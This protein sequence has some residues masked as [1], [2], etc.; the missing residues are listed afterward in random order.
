MNT[1]SIN[2]G[3]NRWYKDPSGG[4]YSI[5]QV[6]EIMFAEWAREGEC[7]AILRRCDTTGKPVDGSKPIQA[8]LYA[9]FSDNGIDFT[10]S[11]A[12]AIAPKTI[13]E[14]DRE[15]DREIYEHFQRKIKS[16]NSQIDRY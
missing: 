13:G 3:K 8:R 9:K 14:G 4:P 7:V 12:L 5:E 11:L 1:Y 6:G 2:I 15:G 10:D 16:Y